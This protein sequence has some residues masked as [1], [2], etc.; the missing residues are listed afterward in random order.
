MKNKNQKNVKNFYIKVVVSDLRPYKK[1]IICGI[2][3]NEMREWARVNPYLLAKTEPCK[4][5][6]K[7]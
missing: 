1:N 4:C 3:E 2:F 6:L 7:R 5:V